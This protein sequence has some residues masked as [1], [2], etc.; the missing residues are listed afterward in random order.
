MG[1]CAC[2]DR[3]KDDAKGKLDGRSGLST[4]TIHSAF[5]DPTGS[6]KHPPQKAMMH[7]IMGERILKKATVIKTVGL[8]CGSNGCTPHPALPIFDKN[9]NIPPLFYLICSFLCHTPTIRI[10]SNQSNH[11]TTKIRFCGSAEDLLASISPSSVYNIANY[12][13]FFE[14]R[15]IFGGPQEIKNGPKL[16]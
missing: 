4:F 2:G 12:A 15:A 9:Q 3:K 13:L 8:I 11:P 16:Y 1:G 14:A 10:S 6:K 5:I 7:C